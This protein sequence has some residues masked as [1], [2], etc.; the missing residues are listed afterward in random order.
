VIPT[1]MTPGPGDAA[2]A[3]L[4]TALGVSPRLAAGDRFVTAGDGVP[5]LAGRVEGAASAPAVRTYHL[6]LEE[7]APGTAFLA[8]EG[9]GEAVAAS[10]YL[11][12]YGA[13][14]EAG[15]EWWSW[16]RSALPEVPADATP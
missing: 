16:L 9:G 11:Y 5:R 13:D 4:C 6:L 2:W 12:L 15:H 1:A 14:D 3:T 8:V 7:P 10:A